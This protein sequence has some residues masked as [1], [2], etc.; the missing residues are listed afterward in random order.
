MINIV[1]DG[2]KEFNKNVIYL[3][4]FILIEVFSCDY[5]WW[6][7]RCKETRLEMSGELPPPQL[8]PPQDKGQEEKHN[9]RKIAQ[10]NGASGIRTNI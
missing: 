5:A 8:S 6:S 1:H 9:L 10:K 4:L 7:F 2:N 3:A